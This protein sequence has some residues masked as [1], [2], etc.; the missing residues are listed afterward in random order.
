MLSHT[1]KILTLAGI[2]ICL[3][4]CENK[5]KQPDINTVFESIKND[6]AKLRQFL[7]VMPK[8][9]D[10]HHHACGAVYAE[11]YIRVALR[12][13]LFI[14]PISFQLYK[15]KNRTDTLAVN[16]NS[17]LKANPQ[18]RDSIIN[19]WSVRHY[20]QSSRDGH[21]WFFNTFYKFFPAFIGNE[22]ELLSVL[23]KKAKA[24]NVQ[25]LETMITVPN[26]DDSVNAL[27]PLMPVAKV[28]N[29]EQ[30]FELWVA[31]LEKAGFEKWVK[32][33]I[34]T[35]NAW[36]ERT[37]KHDVKLKFMEYGVRVVPNHASVFAQLLLAF[38]T[39]HQSP[40]VVGVNFLAPEDDQTALHDYEIHMQMFRFLKEKFPDV[41]VSLHAGELAQGKGKVQDH[42]L[43]FHI[44]SAIKTAKAK[45]I[46]HGVDLL[47]E[48]Y[49]DSILKTMKQNGI[50]VEI[51]LGS[52]EVILERNPQNHPVSVYHKAGVPICISTDDEGVL[53]TDIVEQYLLLLKY[54]PE[55]TYAELK[56]IVTNS[57]EYSFLGRE[58]KQEAKNQ[59]N[60]S[61]VLF[62]SQTIKEGP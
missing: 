32:V 39:A 33:N 16:I 27:V 18:L 35:L 61:F 29:I 20:K 11:D 36:H 28:N 8:G 47:S 14:N 22:P 42:D 7:T 44:N 15:D 21:D 2:M 37:E 19:Y 38:K 30:Q 6:T 41:Q 56:Q 55:L 46:G 26:V 9:A 43:L 54:I 1:F 10:L 45:R 58:E 50:A 31:H 25:Y 57:I 34:D 48:T 3:V 60:E 4:A 59:L 13:S 23:C 40:L 52:N 51:N 53:R 49:K 62:E 12:D 5:T 24:L 17:F